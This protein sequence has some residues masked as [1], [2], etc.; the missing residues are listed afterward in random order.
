MRISTGEGRANEFRMSHEKTDQVRELPIQ[1]K[2][3]P[4]NDP[5]VSQ[6][7]SRNLA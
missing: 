5:C 3:V 1:G 2:Q 6:T 4:V 7:S